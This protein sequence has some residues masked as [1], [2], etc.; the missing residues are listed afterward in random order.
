MRFA[1]LRELTFSAL[2]QWRDGWVMGEN[3]FSLRLN[4]HRVKAFFTW[5]VLHDYLVQ[6]P[7]DKLESITVVE[8]PTLPLSQKEY[9]AMLSHCDAVKEV[10]A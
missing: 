4:S 7:F 9:S 3:S 5:C 2:D 1:K 6:S 10:I 8:I